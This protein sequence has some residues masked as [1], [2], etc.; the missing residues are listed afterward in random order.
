MPFVLAVGSQ[1]GGTGRTTT[2]LALAWLSGTS[3]R[4]VALIDADPIQA[5]V[6]VA[7]APSRPCAWPNVRLFAGLP[8]DDA[9]LGDHD[10]VIVDCPSLTEPEAQK[11]LRR[12]DA[13]LLTCLPELYCLRTLPAAVAALAVARQVHPRLK[14][15]GL[16]AT[17]CRKDDAQHARLLNELRHSHGGLLLKP[18]V[19][20]DRALRDWPQTPGAGL[21]PGAGAA[22]Y[23]ALAEQLLAATTAGAI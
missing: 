17:G 7:A 21:P 22:A 18:P 3:G 20:W 1:K 12:A 23:R 15:L 4:R 14:L 6:L 16:I 13:V 11:V 5:A 2:A 19:P 9:P 8:A 10:L